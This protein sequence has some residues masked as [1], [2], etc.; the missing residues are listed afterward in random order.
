[1]NAMAKRKQG[2][3]LDTQYMTA[4]AID[5]AGSS[6]VRE[7]PALD[8]AALTSTF[9]PPIHPGDDRKYGPTWAA[10]DSEGNRWSIYTCLGTWRIGGRGLHY[11]SDPGSVATREFVDH[12]LRN[13]K[14]HR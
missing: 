14:D 9:G 4:S 12:V 6:L 1:M 3:G 11:P 7:L 5:V 10:K 8:V 2:S 13:C